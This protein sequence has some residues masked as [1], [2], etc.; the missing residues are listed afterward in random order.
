MGQPLPGQPEGMC[1]NGGKGRVGDGASCLKTP[2]PES[3][4]PSPSQARRQGEPSSSARLR[5]K[6]LSFCLHFKSNDNKEALAVEASRCPQHCPGGFHSVL[7]PFLPYS[8][9]LLD[10]NPG[11]LTLVQRLA[12]SRVG[13]Q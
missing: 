13:I 5:Q 4:L 6:G 7:V 3:G 9:L 12:A 2:D 8:W 11:R 1:W 10:S